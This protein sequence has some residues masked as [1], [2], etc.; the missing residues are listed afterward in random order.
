M[1]EIVTKLLE[2]GKGNDWS[3]KRTIEK[4]AKGMEKGRGDKIPEFFNRYGESSQSSWE[5]KQ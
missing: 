1:K 2:E 5:I 4:F 3:I